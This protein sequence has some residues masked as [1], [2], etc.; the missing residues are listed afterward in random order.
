MK[1]RPTGREIIKSEKKYEGRSLYE[2]TNDIIYAHDLEWNVTSVNPAAERILGYAAADIIGKNILTLI[3]SD[4]IPLIKT[5]LETKLKSSDIK[6]D[7]IELIVRTKDGREKWL[8]VNATL[9]TSPEGAPLA[10]HGI[11]RDINDRKLTEQELLISEQKYRAIFENTNAAMGIIEKD[12]ILSLVN[13][14][15][16]KMTG[17]SKRDVEGMRTWMSFVDSRDLDRMMEY[18]VSRLAGHDAPRNY[19]F[20]LICR[21]DEIKNVYI[22]VAFIDGTTQ[23]VISLTDLTE[24]KRA[25]MSLK[26]S[27]ARYR[28]F[29][30]ATSDAAFMKDE[31]SRY[32]LANRPFLEKYGLR[33]E[34]KLL[35]KS[36]NETAL[37]DFAELADKSD[38]MALEAGRLIV[39]EE[40]IRDRV[41]EIRKFP[42]TLNNGKTGIGALVRD[43]TEIRR[44]E[45]EK[46]RLEAAL[47]RASKLEALGTLAGGIAHDL[48]NVLGGVVSLPPLLMAQIPEDSPLKR[49]LELIQRSGEKAAAIVEDMLTLTRRGVSNAKVVNL[50]EIVM[51]HC[52]SPEHDNLRFYHRNVRFEMHLDDYLLNIIGS[53]V[54]LSKAAMNLLSNAAESMPQGGTVTVKTENRY[55]DKPVR[56]YDDIREGDYAVLTVAD[57][58]VGIPPEDLE[59]IFEPFFTKKVMGRSG[60]GLGMTVVWGTVKDHKGYIDVQSREGKGTVFTLYFPATRKKRPDETAH[61][62]VERYRGR[63]E[64]ILIV[65]DV[66]EQ[67]ELASSM[68]SDLGYAI[69]TASSGEIALEYLRKKCV[70][71]VILDMIMDPG[72]DGLETYRRILQIHPGQKAVIASGYSETRSVSEAQKLGAGALEKI[73]I[74]MRNELDRFSG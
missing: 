18:H 70:D 34:S 53:S 1:K 42:V 6:I 63:G 28:T 73:G 37:S 15:F 5:R 58:G 43:V 13:G 55:I 44:A 59:R 22:T 48:N 41:L 47:E 72:I 8:E 45:E 60:T 14:Q 23:R 30:D 3:H 9:V 38:K 11:A 51:T 36:D 71:L 12:N 10:I 46:K 25:E 56:G 7:P 61:T 49:P 17:H 39:I 52:E 21:N 68:L 69:I 32:I 66:P 67:L 35:G 74:A 20:R 29:L 40:Q 54:H 4:M 57:T 62:P 16:E 27:D 33:E 65:D 19:E 2:N 31:N 26:E 64:S 50:N 24:Q